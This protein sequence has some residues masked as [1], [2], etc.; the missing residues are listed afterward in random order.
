MHGSSKDRKVVQ[1]G[2]S[3]GLMRS[4]KEGVRGHTVSE[5]PSEDLRTMPGCG[6][7]IALCIPRSA[8]LVGSMN[9]IREANDCD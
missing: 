8:R 3:V 7:W 6:S 9:G 4:S 1:E 2:P 5:S